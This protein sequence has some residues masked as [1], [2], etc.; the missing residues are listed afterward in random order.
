MCTLH[1]HIRAAWRCSATAPRPSTTS[2]A[3]TPAASPAASPPLSPAVS[4]ILFSCTK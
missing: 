4:I 1:T 3:S 2:V